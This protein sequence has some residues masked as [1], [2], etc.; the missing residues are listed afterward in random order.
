MNKI[1]FKKLSYGV[2]CSYIIQH[3]FFW[4][5]FAI[6][7][8]YRKAGIIFCLFI[9]T[10][11]IKSFAFDSL[12]S[13]S[14]AN[15]YAAGYSPSRESSRQ[16][17]ERIYVYFDYIYLWIRFHLSLHEI[18]AAYQMF[19]IIYDVILQELVKLV[20]SLLSNHRVYNELVDVMLNWNSVLR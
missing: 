17:Y 18:T 7:L 3:T 20:E 15:W 12:F 19:G 4:H 5:A 11:T 8:S 13:M 1:F 10:S 16:A 2:F 14:R 9:K 6:N